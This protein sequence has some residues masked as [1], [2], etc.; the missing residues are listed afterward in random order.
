MS[1]FSKNAQ[2]RRL[3]LVLLLI[4]A[5]ASLNTSPLAGFD[6]ARYAEKHWLSIDDGDRNIEKYAVKR[7]EP[8]YPTLAQKHRIEGI[9]IVELKVSGDGKVMGAQF[10][11]GHSVFRLVALDAAKQWQF[12]KTGGI[13]GIVR[14]TFKLKE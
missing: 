5:L 8:D 10:I 4:V 6:D 1:I 3:R 2:S 14:F 13:E 11:R 9:V 12:K 7:V